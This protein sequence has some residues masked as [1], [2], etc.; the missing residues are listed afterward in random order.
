MITFVEF[1]KNRKISL[2][3]YFGFFIGVF[4]YSVAPD[5]FAFF[6]FN[7]PWYNSFV[8]YFLIRIICAGLF[9]ER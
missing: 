9:N 2:G 1:L 5:V 4:L 7:G 6:G 3:I 8:A